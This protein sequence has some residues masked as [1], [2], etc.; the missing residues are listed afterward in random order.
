MNIYQQH[1]PSGGDDLYLRLKDGDKVKMRIVSEPAITLYKEG[2]RPRYAW[3]IYNRDLGKPQ[4][5]NSGVSVYSQ[6]ADLSEEWGEPTTFDITVKRTG[7]GMQDTEYSVVPVKTSEDLTRAELDE[8]GK[9]DL[10]Q[11][12]KGRML[13]DYLQDKRLPSPIVQVIDPPT[14][15]KD[16]VAPVDDSFDMSQI[17]F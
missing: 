12:T 17:P 13:A 7:S 16:P 1:K 6:I 11:A 5:Y 15:D 10:V 8:V 2:D 14:Q 4:V 9:I 3:V